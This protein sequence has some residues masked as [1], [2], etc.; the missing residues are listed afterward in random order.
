M[1]WLRG[2]VELSNFAYKYEVTSDLTMKTENDAVE[3][4]A[5]TRHLECYEKS[6]TKIRNQWWRWD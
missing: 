2:T 4:K 3:I 6:I 1:E 5:S